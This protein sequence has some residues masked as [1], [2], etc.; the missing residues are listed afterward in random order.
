MSL[1]TAAYVGRRSGRLLLVLLGSLQRSLYVTYTVTVSRRTYH[2]LYNRTR[3]GGQTL[4]SCYHGS[5]WSVC[6]R[7]LVATRRISVVP[8]VMGL[9]ASHMYSNFA[10]YEVLRY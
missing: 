1:L 5:E 6:C 10:R 9:G 8:E 4:A 2:V 3:E 7:R